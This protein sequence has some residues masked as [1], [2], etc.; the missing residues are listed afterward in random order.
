MQDDKNPRNADPQTGKRSRE[1]PDSTLWL[2]DKDEEA[3][4]GRVERDPTNSR[5]KSAGAQDQPAPVAANEDGKS[6]KVGATTPVKADAAQFD[7]AKIEP[8]DTG[9]TQKPQEAQPTSAAHVTTGAQ[10][11]QATEPPSA[12]PRVPDRPVV[13]KSVDERPRAVSNGTMPVQQ[14]VVNGRDEATGIARD[15]SGFAAWPTTADEPRLIERPFFTTERPLLTPLL[16]AAALVGLV[17]AAWSFTALE[18]TRAQLTSITAEKT[19]VDQSLADAQRRLEATEKAIAD[20]QTALG[21]PTGAA[22][23]AAPPKP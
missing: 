23:K 22:A 19:A 10:S 8:T 5:D 21:K 3:P 2:R 6:S 7:A 16:G 14:T 1:L 4:S 18:E 20:V 11:T 17:L 13:A 12:A 15:E 9:A